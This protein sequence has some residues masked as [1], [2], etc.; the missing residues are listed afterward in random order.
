MPA[1]KLRGGERVTLR[2]I[3]ASDKPLIAGAFERMSEDSRYRR[4]F[5]PVRKLGAQE[6]AFLTEVDHHDH[7]AIIAVV[8]GTDA[9]L[10]VARYIRLAEQP[11]EAEAAVAVI[12]DWHGRGLGRALLDQLVERARSEGITHFQALVQADNRGAIEVLRSL[13]PTSTELVGPE[14]ELRIALGDAPG[15]G[16][17]L[18]QALKHAASGTAT[19]ANLVTG[20]LAVARRRLAGRRGSPVLRTGAEIETIVVGTDGSATA[21]RAVAAARDLAGR[22]DAT[23]HVAAVRSPREPPDRA[24]ALV[25]AA[26]REARSSGVA[27]A[28]H[29]REGDP[30]AALIDLAWELDADL[31]VVGSRGMRGGRRFLL[32]PVPDRVSH[33]APCSV[34]IVR[35]E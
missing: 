14:A 7:E 15:A 28:G 4:F 29:A 5:A 8:D 20:R 33:H 23:L 11:E 13:G 1:I 25:A 27:A 6:L 3:E 12:D 34:L 21:A 31:I 10:G 19:F 17:E 32:G 18:A 22:L 2:P 9:A 26:E 24:R 35:T 30:A 16:A